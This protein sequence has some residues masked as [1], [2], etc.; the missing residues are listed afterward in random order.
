[1]RVKGILKEETAKPRSEDDAENAAT[2]PEGKFLDLEREEFQI[3]NQS[4]GNDMEARKNFGQG[5]FNFTMV[6]LIAILLIFIWVGLGRLHYS[7]TVL[8]TFI[9]TTTASAV[10]F[11]VIVFNYLFPNNKK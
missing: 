11:L 8:V 9:T 7:D 3:R 10:G 1:M 2:N 5:I 6:W 4:A